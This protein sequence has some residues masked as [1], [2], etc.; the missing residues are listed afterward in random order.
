MEIDEEIVL[1][2]PV[3]QNSKQPNSPEIPWF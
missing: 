2:S 3:P 1:S